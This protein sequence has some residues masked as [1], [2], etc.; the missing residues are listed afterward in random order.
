MKA[1][2]TLITLLA[3][4]PVTFAAEGDLMPADEFTRLCSGDGVKVTI[5][6]AK[7]PD[8]RYLQVHT[9]FGVTQ[10]FGKVKGATIEA[11]RDPGEGLDITDEQLRIRSEEDDRFRVLFYDFTGAAPGEMHK[12]ESMHDCDK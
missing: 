1:I 9:A 7:Q 2:T 8:M 11:Y 10:Y 5:R 6:E 3:F 12:P 4:A